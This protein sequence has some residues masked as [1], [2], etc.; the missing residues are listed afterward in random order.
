MLKKIATYIIIFFSLIMILDYGIHYSI[1][2]Q[3]DNKSPH[4]LAFTSIGAN[5][6]ESRLDCWATIRTYS[7]SAELETY[8]L[9]IL[10]CLNLPANQNNFLKTTSDDSITLHYNTIF[11]KMDM[12][13]VL[14]SDHAAN[15]TYLV[16]SMVDYDP[17]N[18]LC[19]YEKKLHD[20]TG[21]NW[22]CYDL[23]IASLS[24]MTKPQSQIALLKT[25]NQKLKTEDIDVYWDNNLVSAAG[26][27]PM[28]GQSRMQ[29][30]LDNKKYNFQIAIRNH[31]IEGKTY[32]MIGSPLILGDY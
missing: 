6:L 19:Q 8:L 20:G 7:T 4:Y 22:I 24:Y 13:I 21:F 26:Y 15:E 9:Q 17:Q 1:A 30:T 2:K 3:I 25:I 10:E 18:T 14:E 29:K 32:I 12:S 31:T 28:I 23:H 27:S 5:S 11:E 16:I